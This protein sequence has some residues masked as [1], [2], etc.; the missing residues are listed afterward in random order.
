MWIE[1]FLIVVGSNTRNHL[2]YDWGSFF[3]GWVEIV[4]AGATFGMFAFLYVA[5]SKAFPMIS[6][7]EVKE[8]WRL[9]RWEREGLLESEADIPEV[10]LEP[11]PGASR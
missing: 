5:F 10:V 3:P 11:A 7:W 6:L 9:D 2:S 4:I 1:R 8:G